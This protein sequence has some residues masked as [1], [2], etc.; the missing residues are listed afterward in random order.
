MIRDLRFTILLTFPSSQR[1]GGC[2]VPLK[3]REAT[4]FR[5]DGVVSSAGIQTLA[6]LTTPAFGHPSSAR[7]GIQH[8]TLSSR[9]L[10]KS[11]FGK[12][13]LRRYAGALRQIVQ[14]KMRPLFRLAVDD[15]ESACHQPV[16]KLR[17]TLARIRGENSV[18]IRCRERLDPGRCR[19]HL[20]ID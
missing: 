3:S 9:F 8:K 2:A 19:P 6:G 18:Q 15:P 11:T 12:D 1:R 14:R 4:L 5:A 7:R 13:K 20:D 10:P 17:L 16:F